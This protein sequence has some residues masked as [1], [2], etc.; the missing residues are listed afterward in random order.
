MPETYQSLLANLKL[1]GSLISVKPSSLRYLSNA[2][3]KEA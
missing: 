3:L 2:F 1:I